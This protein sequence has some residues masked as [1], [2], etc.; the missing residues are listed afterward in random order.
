MPKRSSDANASSQRATNNSRKRV[1]KEE[2]VSQVN[3]LE[4]IGE[5]TTPT[6][7]DA[8]FYF[9]DGNVTLRVHHV[10]FKVHITL[11]EAHSEDFCNRFNLYSESEGTCDEDAIIIPEVQPSQFRNL[12]KIIYCL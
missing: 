12:L 5:S 1:K 11:L 8:H 10:I 3:L 2:A 7:Q 6:T 4:D 9:R